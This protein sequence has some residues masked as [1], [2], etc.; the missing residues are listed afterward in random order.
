MLATPGLNR[1][2]AIRGYVHLIAV[3]VGVFASTGLLNRFSD[4]ALDSRDISD[5]LPHLITFVAGGMPSRRPW[6]S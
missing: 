6:Q 4:G 3:M 5:S 2:Q 1:Q